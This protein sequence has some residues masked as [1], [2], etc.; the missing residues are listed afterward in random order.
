MAWP[1]V[2][3]KWGLNDLLMH[4]LDEY[5]RWVHIYVWDFITSDVKYQ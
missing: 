4:I 2:N 3:Q 5:T 1:H